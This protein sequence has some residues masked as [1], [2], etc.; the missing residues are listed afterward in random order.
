MSHGGPNASQLAAL[1]SANEDLFARSGWGRTLLHRHPDGERQLV[2][3]HFPSK[4][5]AQEAAIAFVAA[6]HGPAGDFRV[7]RLK[8]PAD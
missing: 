2:I 4:R 3:G 5:L 7:L 8:A 6:G 1:A